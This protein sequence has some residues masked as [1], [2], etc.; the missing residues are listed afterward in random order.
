MRRSNLV[1]RDRVTYNRTGRRRSAY[2]LRRASLES[3]TIPLSMVREGDRVRIAALGGSKQLKS[4]LIGTGLQTGAELQV[5]RNSTN[6]KL[7]LSHEGSR[8]YLGGEM[9]GKIKVTEI[10]GDKK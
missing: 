4:H 10:K 2:A 1:R 9:A 8:L 5:L 6:G 7:L 3:E